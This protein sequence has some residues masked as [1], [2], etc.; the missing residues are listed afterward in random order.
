MSIQFAVYSICYELIIWG[1]F[2][3]AIFF[4][5]WSAWWIVLAVMMSA[6]QLK[7]KK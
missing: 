2:G 1:F 6:A 4:R 7:E 3:F 5:D